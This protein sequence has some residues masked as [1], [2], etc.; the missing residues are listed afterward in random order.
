MTENNGHM[1][2][3]CLILFYILVQCFM[4]FAAQWMKLVLIGCTHV[5]G[6][7]SCAGKGEGFM[8]LT[9]SMFP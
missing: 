2:I 1:L 7:V 9:K 4:L 3:A 6:I 8:L 5:E